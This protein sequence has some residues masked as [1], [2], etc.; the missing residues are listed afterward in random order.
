MGGPGDPERRGAQITDGCTTLLGSV[1]VGR[2]A[3]IDGGEP[4]VLPRLRINEVT[5]RRIVRL[6]LEG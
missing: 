4:I 1:P 2:F 3:F 5:G 6:E